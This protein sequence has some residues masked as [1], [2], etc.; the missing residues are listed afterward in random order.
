MWGF[1][2]FLMAVETGLGQWMHFEVL[3]WATAVQKYQGLLSTMLHILR[4]YDYHPLPRLTR[5]VKGCPPTARPHSPPPA[6]SHLCSNKTSSAVPDCRW[7]PPSLQ[8]LPTE[9]TNNN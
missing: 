4:R 6:V 3:S 7:L 1:E 8:A 9:S 5:P 2:D